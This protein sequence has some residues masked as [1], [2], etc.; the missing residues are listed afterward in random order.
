MDENQLYPP[1]DAVVMTPD[2]ARNI[3]WRFVTEAESR[4]KF[5]NKSRASVHA[6]IERGEMATGHRAEWVVDTSNALVDALMKA[7]HDFNGTY[8]Y[9]VAMLGDF[10]DVLTTTKARFLAAAGVDLDKK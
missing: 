3:L 7:G 6:Q 2:L 1:P 10:L 5:A 4:V 8:P 9:D